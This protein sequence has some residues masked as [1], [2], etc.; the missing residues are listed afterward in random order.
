[1][2][3]RIGIRPDLLPLFRPGENVQAIFQA[4][5]TSPYVTVFY[6]NALAPNSS[7][8]V[9]VTDQ[10]ILVCYAGRFRAALVR[11]VER[12]LPR[13]ITIGS[14]RGFWWRCDTLGGRLYVHKQFHDEIRRADQALTAA[15]TPPGR[16]S[17]AA[18][19]APA[20][21]GSGPRTRSP[22]P[23]RPG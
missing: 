4:Q 8:V 7:R 5:T 12:E 1:M 17:R 20:A 10:R 19:A 6:R 13:A 23:G 18:A 16:V 3:S 15:L 9:V 11:G 22:R 21:R 2:A 14:P